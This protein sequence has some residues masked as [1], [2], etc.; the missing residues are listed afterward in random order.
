MDMV[1]SLTLIVVLVT[2]NDTVRWF[3]SIIHIELYG[4]SFWNYVLNVLVLFLSTDRSFL[5]FINKAL[6]NLGDVTY[7]VNN[8]N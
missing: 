6:D 8:D 7:S 2:N 3:M 1:K 4:Q 5:K